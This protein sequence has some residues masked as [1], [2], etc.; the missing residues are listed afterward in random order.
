MKKI[1][2]S[3]LACAFLLTGCGTIPKLENGEEVVA[4][5]DGKSFTANDLYLKLKSYYGTSALVDMI[6]TQIAEKE[7]E[8][9]DDARKYA[10][11]ELENIKYQY[12]LYNMDFEEALKQANETEDELLDEIILQYKKDKVVENYVKD[13]IT[14]EE[15]QSY[16]D[17]NIFGDMTAKHI[18]ITP[19]VT[20]D[21]SDDEKAMKE[22]EALSKAQDL[23][24]QLN[25]GADFEELAKENS[26]DA[27]TASQGG[28]ISG[29]SKVGSNS[30]VP[31]FW[32]AAYNL[33]DNEYTS[34]PV[35]STYGYHIILKVSQN[36]R[37]SLED[38]RDDIKDTLAE[39][40]LTNDTNLS[41]KSWVEIR[42]KYNLN[43]I[44]S[45]IKKIYDQ[46]IESYK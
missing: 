7:I 13:Q 45:D 22:N 32:E 38:T 12:E 1:L 4:E 8:T 2:L 23:I 20:N 39:E 43:I 36:E 24:K 26:D 18:L 10:K 35:K 16:Y 40:K 29:F 31:V 3:T 6:N 34:E 21:M 15:I 44:D 42:K 14:D 37:P 9:D 30:V 11:S 5:I 33:K 46:T 41:E 27:G 25:D 17:E 19:D 28:L